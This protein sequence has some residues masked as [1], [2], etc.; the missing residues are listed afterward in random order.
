MVRRHDEGTKW[1]EETIWWAVDMRKRLN[2][3]S[4][5]YGDGTTW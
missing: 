3:G 2:G 4:G 5:L 1:Q